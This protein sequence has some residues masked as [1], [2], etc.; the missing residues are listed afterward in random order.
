MVG[1]PWGVR[2]LRLEKSFKNV[3]QVV[4]FFP[5]KRK[6]NDGIKKDRNISR[7]F[8]QMMSLSIFL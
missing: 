4:N 7:N 1:I 5:D 6:K 2:Y 3:H 8:L